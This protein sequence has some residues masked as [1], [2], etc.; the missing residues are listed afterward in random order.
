MS[1]YYGEID[2]ERRLQQFE[3]Y[4]REI[5]LLFIELI[6]NTENSTLSEELELPIEKVERAKNIFIK[7]ITNMSALEVIK[8]ADMIC[9]QVNNK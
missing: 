4:G 8:K 5:K 7:R 9:K 2:Y 3:N 1:D 6:V